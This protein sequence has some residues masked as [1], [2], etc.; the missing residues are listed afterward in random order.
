M[1]ELALLEGIEGNT[2]QFLSVV[3]GIKTVRIHRLKRVDDQ[4]FQESDPIKIQMLIIEFHRTD[5]CTVDKQFNI[6]T[7]FRQTELPTEF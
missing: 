2:Y 3:K 1:K 5:E 4:M 6:I 7:I